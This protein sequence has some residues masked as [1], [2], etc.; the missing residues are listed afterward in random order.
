MRGKSVILQ[1]RLLPKVHSNSTVQ[2]HLIGLGVFLTLLPD[3]DPGPCW[4]SPARSA[5]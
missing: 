1:H 2:R 5:T 4:H 3:T